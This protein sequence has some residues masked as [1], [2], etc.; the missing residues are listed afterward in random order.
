M[1]FHG[2]HGILLYS[3]TLDLNDMEFQ[4]FANIPRCLLLHYLYNIK[5]AITYCQR[6]SFRHKREMAPGSSSALAGTI[7]QGVI[8]SE[9]P[10]KSNTSNGGIN[11]G[12]GLPNS[13]EFTIIRFFLNDHLYGY[14]ATFFSRAR[15]GKREMKFTQNRES[16]ACSG[17]CVCLTARKTGISKH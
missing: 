11:F 13:D 7:I 9:T 6:F 1:E 5:I 15:R 16:A 3:W 2:M 4:V 8:D 17:V 14:P 10:R 12:D